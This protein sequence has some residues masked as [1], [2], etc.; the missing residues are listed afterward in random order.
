MEIRL[1]VVG[2]GQSAVVKIQIEGCEPLVENC[3]ADD[4]AAAYLGYQI[5]RRFSSRFFVLVCLLVLARNDPTRVA[6][7]LKISIGEDG[8]FLISD[9][10][11]LSPLFSRPTLRYDLANHFPQRQAAGRVVVMIKER[12]V[13]LNLDRQKLT[14]DESTE[15]LV[16]RR[17][18]PSEREGDVNT[19]CSSLRC[20]YE[21]RY[22][23]RFR[24]LPFGGANSGIPEPK[25]N[26][27]ELDAVYLQRQF[28]APGAGDPNQQNI[29]IE[30]ASLLTRTQ[31]LIVRGAAGTGKSTW[32][33]WLFRRLI[34][35]KTSFPIFIELP[36]LAACW[37]DAVYRG[38]P[39]TLEAYIQ[40]DISEN[41]GPEWRELVIRI[42]QQSEE[43]RPILLIDGWDEIGRLGDEVRVKLYGFLC[44]YK[45]VLAI[46][47]SRPYGIGQPT[48]PGGFE[49]LDIKP[50]EAGEIKCLASAVFE[51]WRKSGRITEAA[52]VAAGHFM[53]ALAKVPDVAEL[54]RTP[55]FLMILLS[56]DSG[57]PLPV[58]R[59]LVIEECIRQLTREPPGERARQGWPGEWCP[60]EYNQTLDAL[61][62]LAFQV[63]AQVSPIDCHSDEQR[64]AMFL[65]WLSIVRQLPIQWSEEQRR[66]FFTWAAGSA[67]L[68]TTRHADQRVTF[69]HLVFQEFLTAR[70]LFK[71]ALVNVA[72]MAKCCRDRI[73][74]LNW[75]DTLRFLLA[76]L[77]E[78]NSATATECLMDLMR[79]EN[80]GYWLAGS[81]IADGLG[82]EE[83]MTHWI[84]E[85][86]SHLGPTEWAE[87]DY[88]AWVWRTSHENR[89]REQLYAALDRVAPTLSWLC[90][91]RT[92]LF[93]LHAGFTRELSMPPRNTLARK[94]LNVLC[95]GRYDKRAVAVSRVCSGAG[96][97]YPEHMIEVLLLRLWP[98]MRGV[99]GRWLQLISSLNSTNQT[100]LEMGAQFLGVKFAQ[101]IPYSKTELQSPDYYYERYLW[102]LV[103]RLMPRISDALGKDIKSNFANLCSPYFAKSLAADNESYFSENRKL[104]EKFSRNFAK[105][106]IQRYAGYFN[107]DTTR[108]LSTEFSDP[109]IPSWLPEFCMFEIASMGH[110][111]TAFAIAMSAATVSENPAWLLLRAT[112]RAILKFDD[113]RLVK[114]QL[115]RWP[116][117]EDLLWPALARY[118]LGEAKQEDRQLLLD[119]AQDPSLRQGPLSWGLAYYVRGD[120]VMPDGD[121]DDL[122]LDEISRKYGLTTLPH[123]GEI[124]WL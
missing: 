45:R 120:V 83:L 93:R 108:R 110:Y 34:K 14:I 32:L 102:Q 82:S 51:Q 46:V 57:Q 4:K 31:S 72:D 76:R 5:T 95:A 54:A 99:I 60:G 81:S 80:K 100:V 104:S 114:A 68:L 24:D 66:G 16:L 113:R 64:S 112:C 15:E 77:S 69:R 109:G 105:K 50:L 27:L 63:Q 90:W 55:L 28:S 21:S 23:S 40:E 85:L 92:D 30:L 89:W 111:C 107:R 37:E 2:S 19:T 74:S 17:L 75:W 41:V 59:H 35:E 79:P 124:P 103:N 8:S 11:T 1:I 121:G 58:R 25:L 12:R 49:E 84:S 70:Y 42:L 33:K 88:C 65:P 36:K 71:N 122:L 78:E 9:L 22:A 18:R 118:L 86:P 87:L 29:V 98:S 48:Q 106:Y 123:L 39:R 43:P 13:W 61:S 53:D 6:D 26:I 91:L 7:I 20:A 44:T 94:T 3:D 115:E 10:A 62:A 97:F 101:A 47:C 52:D 116:D 67:G 117:S 38:R 119:L 73:E 96:P 56:L